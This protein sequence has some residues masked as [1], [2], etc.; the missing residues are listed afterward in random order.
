MKHKVLLSSN[1]P[2]I[3]DQSNLNYNRAV[4]LWLVDGNITRLVLSNDDQL[5]PDCLFSETG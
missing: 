5:Q 4:K 3:I 2:S 1:S